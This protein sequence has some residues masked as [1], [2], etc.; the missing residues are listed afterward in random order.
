MDLQL[1]G[2]VALVTAAS[3]G[4]GRATA[5]RLAAEGARVMISSRGEEQLAKTAAEIAEATGAQVEYCP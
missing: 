4:L 5:T 1:T 3:K 2:K